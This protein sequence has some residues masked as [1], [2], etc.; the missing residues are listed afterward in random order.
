VIAPGFAADVMPG[1]FKDS[2]SAKEIDA[3][4]TYLTETK[5]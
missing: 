4:V 2:L 1:N 3:L 5:Q